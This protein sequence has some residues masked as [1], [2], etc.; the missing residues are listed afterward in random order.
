M[1]VGKGI[2]LKRSRVVFVVRLKAIEY[3]ERLSYYL[4]SYMRPLALDFQLPAL[5]LYPNRTI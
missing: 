5:Y 2:S 3:Y 4:S 1:E